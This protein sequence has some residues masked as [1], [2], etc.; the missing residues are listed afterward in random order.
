MAACTPACSKDGWSGDPNPRVAHNFYTDP[1]TGERHCA[2][3]GALKPLAAAVKTT[4]VAAEGHAIAT[5][6]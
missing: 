5:S 3:C 6:S 4:I 1:A 2:W